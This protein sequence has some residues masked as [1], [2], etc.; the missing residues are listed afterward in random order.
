M[1]ED[2]KNQERIAV[3]EEEMYND[4]QLIGIVADS[5]GVK[6]IISRG[7]LLD[8]VARMK[9]VLGEAPKKNEGSQE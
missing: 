9:K 3:L 2:A 7:I 1:G 8:L 6:G 4:I 5:P